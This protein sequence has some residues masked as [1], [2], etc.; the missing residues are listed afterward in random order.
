MFDIQLDH[1]FHGFTHL[2]AIDG[3]NGKTEL[4]LKFKTQIGILKEKHI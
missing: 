4:C 2:D 3:E 1:V